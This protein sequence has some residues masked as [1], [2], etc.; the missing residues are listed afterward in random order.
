MSGLLNFYLFE[1]DQMPK[2]V[3]HEEAAE[4]LAK[5]EHDGERKLVELQNTIE[6]KRCAAL[7]PCRHCS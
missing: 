4:E 7:L 1:Q 6:K 5:A 3:A 2:L